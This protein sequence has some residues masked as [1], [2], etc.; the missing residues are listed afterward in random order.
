[1][2]LI[3]LALAAEAHFQP[4]PII[5]Q[6]LSQCIRTKNIHAT[7]DRCMA[8]CPTDAIQLKRGLPELNPE[9][10]I[11]CGVCLHTCPVGVFE[12]PDSFQ[13]LLL[14]A[15]SLP[16][17]RCI[18][19]VCVH[20]PAP[21]KAAPIV[22]AV[23]Q[24]QNCLAELGVSA[25]IG[26]LAAGV[27][28]VRIRLDAC[29]DCPLRVL[30]PNIEKCIAQSQQFP[31]SLGLSDAIATVYSAE[32][33]WNEQPVY[34]SQH[35]PISRRGL[36]SSILNPEVVLKQKE[37]AAI[38]DDEPS[39]QLPRERRRLLKALRLLVNN[40]PEVADDVGINNESFVQLIAS[41]ACNAC[42]LCERVCPTDAI[43]LIKDDEEFMVTFEPHRCT[44][45]QLCMGYC[46][47]GALQ[48]YD[49]PSLQ[50]V[51]DG[52]TVQLYTGQMKQCKRCKSH[53]A[54]SS[55]ESLCPVCRFRR[56]SPYGV[57][58][59]DTILSQLPDATRKKLLDA[60]A[61]KK[62]N[63]SQLPPKAPPREVRGTSGKKK[64][65]KNSLQ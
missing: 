44:N 31:S 42:G 7:C 47:T 29:A 32:T 56:Q 16:D 26:L 53:F 57:Q 6:T 55:D 52:S 61:L 20:H 30:Q 63:R 2:N 14:T 11:K 64:T 17:H 46:E 48:F 24:T 9:Q 5:E 41:D 13:K 15:D 22:D 62:A 58:L 28:Q 51:L 43:H 34:H 21:Q 45:C 38:D 19:L 39:E 10:C 36:F 4:Q 37:I 49:I 25:Y 1:M 59:P 50:Y 18:D 40:L 12:R 27:E 35:P 60:S 23:V 8:S 33:D 54:G 3:E 65:C